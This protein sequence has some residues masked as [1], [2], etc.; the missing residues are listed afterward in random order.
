MNLV[1]DQDMSIENIYRLCANT[2]F[3]IGMF[4]TDENG[5]TTVE[6]GMAPLLVRSNTRYV[7]GSNG[8]LSN[9]CVLRGGEVQV[10][11]SY[12]LFEEMVFNSSLQGITFHNATSF[13]AILSNEGELTFQ[14]CAFTV[15]TKQ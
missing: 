7:C 1:V 4:L 8:A 11:S 12:S 10:L 3:D 14:D 13:G 6:G 9:N 5:T 2:T 15:R